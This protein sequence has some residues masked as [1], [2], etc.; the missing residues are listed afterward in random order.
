MH[1]SNNVRSAR[2]VWSFPSGLHDIG[3]T[4]DQTA[5]RELE[6]E[7]SLKNCLGSCAIY[8]YDNIAG[9]SDSDE[10]YH[11]IM[12]VCVSVF[13][14]LDNAEN[15]E[16]EKHDEMRVIEVTELRSSRFWKVHQF[17]ESFQKK[18]QPNRSILVDRIQDVIRLVNGGMATNSF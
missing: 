8:A 9:D 15:K 2:N 11:W 1:R 17:H 10:Q 4:W 6:E 5:C 18:F 13:D 14:S 3:E 12:T 16:P 7:Y